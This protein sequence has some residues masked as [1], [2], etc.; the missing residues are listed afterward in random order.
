MF[1]S[2]LSSFCVTALV[3]LFGFTFDCEEPQ[4][5]TFSSETPLKRA[6]VV[7]HRGDEQLY[8]ENSMDAFLSGSKAGADFVEMDVRRTRDG[9]FIIHHDENTGRSVHCPKGEV[10]IATTTFSYL[11][12][13]CRYLNL[14]VDRGMVLTLSE[15]LSLMRWTRTGLVLDVKPVIKEH[16]ILEFAEELLRLDPQGNCARGIDLGGTFN[17]FSNLIIYVNDLDAHNKL[18]R[19]AKGLQPGDPRYRVL[20]AMKY[21][22][23][24]YEAKTALADP[25]AYLDNDGLAFNLMASSVADIQQM[26][27]LYPNK[28]FAV[29]TLSQTSEF[30]LAKS[31]KM[32]GIITSLLHDY[33]KYEKTK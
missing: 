32:D 30:D 16:E 18:W 19:V 12:N 11:R 10:A 20:S 33:L 9:S 24:T 15:T 7:A 13:E 14:A 8:P 29:W 26:R 23:I 28:I 17:C 2:A 25:E 31:L 5:A 4:Q 1:K 21:L 22:K 27:A 6:F 3:G